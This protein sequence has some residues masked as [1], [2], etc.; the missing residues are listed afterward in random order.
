MRVHG[1]NHREL[2][3]IYQLFGKLK[4]DLEQHML[5]EE[6]LLFPILNKPSDHTTELL[7]L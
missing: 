5:K 4:T 3:K 1:K 2:Y 6:N 7:S